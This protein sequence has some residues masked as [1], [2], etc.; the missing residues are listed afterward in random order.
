VFGNKI[1]DTY[2]GDYEQIGSSQDPIFID[3]TVQTGKRYMYYVLVEA[4]GEVSDQSNLVTFPLLSPPMTFARLLQ[5]VDRLDERHRLHGP[6]IR[7]TKVRQQLADAQT[8][9][10]ECQITA[11][12]QNLDPEK[13]STIARKPD[14]ADLEIV[15]AKLVRRL[16]LFERLP[17]DVSSDEFCTQTVTA[18]PVGHLR[19]R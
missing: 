16:E 15:M 8:L 12:L 1:P 18:N 5:D 4:R 2:V 10:A 7:I 19:G 13:A 9:A 6:V 3:S 11:A 17:Q 14:A